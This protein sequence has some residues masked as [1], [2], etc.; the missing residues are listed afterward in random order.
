MSVLTAVVFP[1]Q[2]S[3]SVG[4]LSTLENSALVRDTF[5]EASTIL[6]YDLWDLIQQGPAEKLNQSEFTQPALLVASVALWRCYLETKKEMPTLLAGHSLGEYTALVCADALRFSDAVALVRERAICMQNAVPAGQGAMAA[7][8]G[9]SDE[10]VQA[11]CLEASNPDL[12]N[13]QDVVS[14]ANYNSP[15]QVVI[16]GQKPAVD[17]AMKLAQEYGAKR[18]ILLPVSV[19]SHCILMKPAADQFSK[20]LQKTIFQS[21][22][23][24]ILHNVDVNSHSDPEKIRDALIA[25]LYQPVRW[26][27]IIQKMAVQGIERILECGPGSVLTGLNKRI[28]SNVMCA[29][30]L[31]GEMICP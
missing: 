22:Q 19:P 14:A 6:G 20:T 25:Q 15:G 24:P 29:T 31:S 7:I 28:V 21:P 26:V 11:L 27:E 30:V 8:L 10:V 18:A 23:I 5:N 13:A 9:L 2:G 3:Q 17:R 4:M 16:A 1:G 12:D